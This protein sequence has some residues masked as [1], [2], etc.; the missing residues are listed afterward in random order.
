[1]AIANYSIPTKLTFY[2]SYLQYAYAAGLINGVDYETENEITDEDVYKL[3]I[4]DP[5]QTSSFDFSPEGFIAYDLKYDN[6]NF[7][8]GMILGHNMNNASIILRPSTY[9]IEGE[10]LIPN[11]FINTTNI[12]NYQDNSSISYNGWSAFNLTDVPTDAKGIG[13]KCQNVGINPDLL[14]MGSFLFG[15]KWEAPQNIE[16]NSSVNYSYGFKQK[17]TIGGKTISHMNY[18]KPNK[19][20]LDAWELSSEQS[21]TRNEATDSRNGIRTWKVSW[22]F[23]QDKYAMNQNNMQNS[24]GWDVDENSDYSIGADGTSL[25]N[26]SDGIDFY[27]SVIKPTMGGHLPCVV[28]ISESNN[29]DQFAIVR[30]KKYSVSQKS[31]KFVSVKLT[32]EEQV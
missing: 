7:D 20:L 8:F 25:Y 11:E 4:L 9:N 30:I 14:T 22:N 32:L 1:M 24:A 13:L 23:L 21:D 15:K 28:K 29:P 31:P 6:W 16:M 18:Y 19:W 27:T 3:A 5:S 26:S 12:K 17:K 10:E 2:P